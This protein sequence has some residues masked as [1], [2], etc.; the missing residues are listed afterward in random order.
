MGMGG[1][2]ERIGRNKGTTEAVREGELPT[3]GSGRRSR[4]THTGV[5]VSLFGYVCACACVCVCGRACVYTVCAC[6]HVGTSI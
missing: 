1:K 4:K 5:R 2:D 6:Q 3:K